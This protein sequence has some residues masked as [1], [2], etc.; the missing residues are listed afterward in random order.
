MLKHTEE[1]ILLK[2]QL[3]GHLLCSV[4]KKPS[5]D[6]REGDRLC[7]MGHGQGDHGQHPRQGP[8]TQ[9]GS[10]WPS[11]LATMLTVNKKVGFPVSSERE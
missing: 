9:T 6:S 10:R 3:V 1:C 4:H 7:Q 2:N 11:P 8:K 5:E